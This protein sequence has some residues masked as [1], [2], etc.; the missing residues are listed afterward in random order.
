MTNV[1]ILYVCTGELLTDKHINFAQKLVGYKFKNIYG[2]Q[3]TLTLHKATRVPAKCA[4]NFLQ[5]MHCR[6]SHWIVASTI[7]SYPKVTVYDSLYNS[8]DRNT[9]GI[10]KQL[11]GPKVEVVINNDIKQIGVEDCGL[12]AIANCLCLAEDRSPPRKF[13]QAKMRQHLVDCIEN[14]NLTMFPCITAHS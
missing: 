10:L 6:N 11:F 4:K 1:V 8:I 5:I 12:F 14:L 2:L 13:D 7:L 9:T 3:L